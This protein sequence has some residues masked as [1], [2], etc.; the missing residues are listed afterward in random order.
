MKTPEE[1]Y[2]RRP[3]ARLAKIDLEENELELIEGFVQIN[4]ET[5]ELE[6]T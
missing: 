6:T 5:G 3:L 4:E 2:C 1:Y